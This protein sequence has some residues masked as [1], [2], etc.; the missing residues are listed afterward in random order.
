MKYKPYYRRNLPHYHPLHGTFFITF[1]L[2]NT[3]PASVI[4]TMREEFEIQLAILLQKKIDL[5]EK[6]NRINALENDYFLKIDRVFDKCTHGPTY[7]KDKSVAK[8]LTDKIHSYDKLYY[9]L[10]AY[11][12]MPNHVHLLIDLGLQEDIDPK[13]Q[14]YPIPLIMKYIK[15]WSGRKS[16]HFLG[17]SGQFW[18]RESFDTYIRDE[19]HLSNVVSYIIQ[20]PVKARLVKNWEEWPYT[21]VAQ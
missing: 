13:T 5:I 11:T 8:I 6:Q 20:N 12:I 17:R 1:R 19:R 14:K 16:N 3:I 10:I 7:L 21:Y 9:D 18:A 2:A 4:A 15:G